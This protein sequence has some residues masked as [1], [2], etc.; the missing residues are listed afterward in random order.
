MDLLDTETMYQSLGGTLIS[1]P[2][3][4]TCKKPD[5]W[6]G[7]LTGGQ[8]KEGV[9]NKAVSDTAEKKA[10]REKERREPVNGERLLTDY[11]NEV[12]HN[13]LSNLVGN[14]EVSFT[15]LE[16]GINKLT[17]GCMFLLNKSR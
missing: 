6:K 5:W 17:N 2:Y 16:I 1:Q 13:K 14:C 11:F 12:L 10:K 4:R 15:N 7:G 3:L 9:S 8:D